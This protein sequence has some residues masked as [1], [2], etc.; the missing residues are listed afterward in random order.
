VRRIWPDGTIT[1]VAG[2][3]TAGFGGDG[4]PATAAQLAAPS[5]V[6]MAPDGWILIAD[7]NNNR[8]RRVATDGKIS[9]V[10][11]TAAGAGY[12]GDN[13]AATAAQVNFPYDVAITTDGGYLIA[14]ADNQRI[15]GA[16][17]A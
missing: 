4:G 16:H 14:D 11:G 1:T 15:R 3:G 2:D 7:A 5:G 13:Q 8:V 17:P 9:T 10:A 6:A 12:N